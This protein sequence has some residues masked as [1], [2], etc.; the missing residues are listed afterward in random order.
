MNGKQY[1]GKT[2]YDIERRWK[3]H[4]KNQRRRIVEKRP[5][6]DAMKKYGIE[7]FSIRELEECSIDSSS[8]REIY[9]I[10]KL[11]TYSNGY[12]ATKGGDGKNL[13]DYQKIADKYL[14]LQNQKETAKYF[15]CDPDTVKRAC[16]SCN[17]KML[18]GQEVSKRNNSQAVYQIDKNTK[19]V[20]NIFY[21]ISE[22]SRV[23]GINNGSISKVCRG[24]RQ[25]A[26]G[27]I[28]KLV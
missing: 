19:K 1:V 17:I 13:Y 10:N 26:D 3:E 22:A 9:W 28:W 11:D 18:S 24:V 15:G 21:S 16:D 12:N 8:E 7:N 23:T 14:E 25:T 6:Y 20:L 5:L 4:I 27:F 2:T